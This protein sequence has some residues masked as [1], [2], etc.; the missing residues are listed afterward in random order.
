MEEML[1]DHHLKNKV[2]NFNSSSI[3]ILSNNINKF[4][5]QSHPS[6]TKLL[7][8]RVAVNTFTVLCVYD[9][10]KIFLKSNGKMLMKWLSEQFWRC[11]SC[12][13][14]FSE[15]ADAEVTASVKR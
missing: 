7:F 12:K 13:S 10:P 9:T 4:L 6:L 1:Y 2:N 3:Y 11:W 8:W 14:S 15:T 5:S